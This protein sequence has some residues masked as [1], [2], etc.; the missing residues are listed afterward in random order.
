M[1][2]SL[3]N[4]FVKVYISIG[5]GIRLISKARTFFADID[6]EGHGL[7]QEKY[8]KSWLGLGPIFFE[9]TTPEVFKTTFREIADFRHSEK[10]NQT[11]ILGAGLLNKVQ[12]FKHK[13]KKIIK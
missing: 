3:K 1:L 4:V 11:H 8:L 5:K 6:K 13:S 2:S 7:N 10:L 9:S 12:F